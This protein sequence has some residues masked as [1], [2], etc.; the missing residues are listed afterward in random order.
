[1]PTQQPV[2]HAFLLFLPHSRSLRPRC[3]RA[4]HGTSAVM[5]ALLCSDLPEDGPLECDWLFG[6]GR[7]E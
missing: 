3:L 2:A 5:P 6:A 4:L 7:V 1:M